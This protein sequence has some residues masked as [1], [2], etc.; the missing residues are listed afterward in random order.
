MIGFSVNP[1]ASVG[2]YCSGVLNR[3]FSAMFYPRPSEDDS[4][5]GGLE[6]FRYTGLTP[7]ELNA[8][9][10]S[11]ETIE[12]VATIPYRTNTLVVFPN[13]PR[14]VHGSEVREVTPH[15]RAYVFITAEVEKDLF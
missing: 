1:A 13:G 2:D 10:L 3:L 7:D 15:Q 6:L 5:G 14:A 4:I 8:F 12:C 9:E 11:P